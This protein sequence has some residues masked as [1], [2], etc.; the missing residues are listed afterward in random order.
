MEWRGE[1]WERRGDAW[2]EWGLGV[3]VGGGVTQVV[4]D[5]EHMQVLGSARQLHTHG[6]VL[7]HFCIRAPAADKFQLVVSSSTAVDGVEGGH[8]VDSDKH[9]HKHAQSCVL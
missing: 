4:A 8:W 9:T 3:L 5:L 1:G 7:A 2:H 6:H